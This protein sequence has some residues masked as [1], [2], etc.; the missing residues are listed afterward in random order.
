MSDISSNGF[1]FR[2]HWSVPYHILRPF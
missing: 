1:P 2:E